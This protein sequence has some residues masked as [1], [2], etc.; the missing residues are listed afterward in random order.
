MATEPATRAIPKSSRLGVVRP[1]TSSPSTGRWATIPRAAEVNTVIA[2]PT[3]R[4]RR[5]RPTSAN[6][7][8]KIAKEALRRGR[9]QG[10][11]NIA[12]ITTA[13]LSANSPRVAIKL[14]ATVSTT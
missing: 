13:A 7:P 4:V 6:R 14:A 10:A 11:I 2:T 9:I 1:S 8:S 5:A 3:A 12:P